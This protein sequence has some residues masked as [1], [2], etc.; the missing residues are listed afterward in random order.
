MRHFTSKHG[1]ENLWRNSFKMCLLF[2]S[3]IDK[4]ENAGVFFTHYHRG[5]GSKAIWE[6]NHENLLKIVPILSN[7]NWY[8][9]YSQ[10]KAT[11]TQLLHLKLDIVSENSL[12]SPKI[13][14]RAYSI[15]LDSCN[16][17]SAKF[18]QT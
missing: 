6:L 15:A 18:L 13:S 7:S 10:Q 4:L 11:D 3:S 8:D 14:L 16:G 5:S 17:R 12:V 9:G 1:F 2:F